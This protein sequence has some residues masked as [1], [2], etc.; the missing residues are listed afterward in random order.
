[1][2]STKLQLKCT[3]CLLLVATITST[4][5]RIAQYSGSATFTRSTAIIPTTDIMVT[6]FA[7]TTK[8]HYLDVTTG[9]S[10]G[11]INNLPG[12]SFYLISSVPGT[13][14]YMVGRESGITCFRDVNDDSFVLDITIDS[15]ANIRGLGSL[16]AMGLTLIGSDDGEVHKWDLAGPTEES[17]F[18]MSALT[19]FSS[20]TAYYTSDVER[21]AQG[22]YFIISHFSVNDFITVIDGTT[23]GLVIAEIGEGGFDALSPTFT[24]TYYYC[25]TMSNTIQKRLVSDSSLDSTKTLATNSKTLDEIKG[26]NWIICHRQN[27]VFVIF[28][29]NFADQFTHTDTSVSSYLTVISAHDSKPYFGIV[30]FDNSKTIS[31][32]MLCQPYLLKQEKS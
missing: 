15:T 11:D 29:E 31:I 24:S 26:M 10:V 23:M 5:T 22:D 7:T 20:E 16:E 17:I 32:F 8:V 30:S 14:K 2:K 28:D 3:I 13:T 12:S 1:M 9:N 19:E 27:G 18:R 21:M 4:T 6:S 25:A